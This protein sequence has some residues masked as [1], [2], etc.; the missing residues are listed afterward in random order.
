MGNT[1]TQGVRIACN[2]I[3]KLQERTLIGDVRVATDK[4]V[5]TYGYEDGALLP[6][7]LRRPTKKELLPF[8]ATPN[9]H[10]RLT[11]VFFRPPKELIG[12]VRKDFDNSP[13]SDFPNV[14]EDHEV[15]IVKGVHGTL[16]DVISFSR[17]A[18]TS[19]VVDPRLKGNAAYKPGSRLGLH[20]DKFDG[21]PLDTRRQRVILHFGG[22]PRK[23]VMVVTTNAWEIAKEHSGEPDFVT[24]TNDAREYIRKYPDQTVLLI[25][26]GPGEAYKLPHQSAI[27]DGIIGGP[28]TIAVFDESRTRRWGSNSFQQDSLLK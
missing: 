1:E 23:A 24:R 8:L 3:Q 22:E 18:P 2:N 27:H 9:T 6:M 26:F 14:K 25:E 10:P 28:S 20:L 17:N 7:N 5:T 4:E 21:P 12:Q 19:S 13:N 16:V 11:V 15:E